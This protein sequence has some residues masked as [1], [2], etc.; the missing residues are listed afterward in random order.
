MV[1]GL[2]QQTYRPMEVIFVDGGSTDGTTDII[3][4]LAER[5]TSDGF[6]LRLLREEDYGA[7]RSPANARNIGIMNAK[8]DYVIFFDADFSLNADLQVIEKIVRKFKDARAEHI[9]ILFTP[10]NDTWIEGNL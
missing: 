6:S 4:A 9:A 7:L 8:G 10:N 5:C 2:F 3:R 1:E